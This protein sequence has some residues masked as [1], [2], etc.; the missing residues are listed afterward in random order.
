MTIDA[1]KIRQTV[2]ED[3][4]QILNLLDIG[5]GSSSAKLRT[6]IFWQ[7]KHV[8]QPFGESI[9][10]VAEADGQIVGLRTFMRWAFSNLDDHGDKHIWQAVRAVDTVTHPSYRRLGIFRKLNEVALKAAQ[11]AGVDLIFNTPNAQSGAGYLKQGWHNVGIL[12]LYF[13]ID[14]W[15]DSIKAG[16]NLLLK[17]GRQSG[18]QWQ[19]ET[20]EPISRQ[21]REVF[22]KLA[23]ETK[24][25]NRQLKTNFSPGYFRWRYAEH[26]FVTYYKLPFDQ[27]NHYLIVRPNIRFGVRELVI[28]EV[29]ESINNGWDRDEIENILNRCRCSYVVGHSNQY[30]P[31]QGFFKGIGLRTAPQQFGIN[32]FVYPL[33]KN[34]SLENLLRLDKWA[35]SLGTLEVF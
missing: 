3:L 22:N 25:G 24:I 13:R 17:K 29:P 2:D 31:N 28:C 7:W 34:A 11:E 18:T 19:P 12:P 27:A 35:F 32:L 8:K 26:P 20:L 23:M 4:P 10:Y 5:L 16:Y 1:I 33:S 6:K 9:V 15:K 14:R 30:H 21:D